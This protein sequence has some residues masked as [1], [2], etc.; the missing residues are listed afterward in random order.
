MGSIVKIFPMYPFSMVTWVFIGKKSF[1]FL[2]L[3]L[4][5]CFEGE[6]ERASTRG[7]Q[8]AGETEFQ[9][10]SE[11]SAQSLNSRTHEITTWAEIKSWTLNPVG[12]PSAPIGTKFYM[13]SPLQ[14]KRCCLP[15]KV[16]LQYPC[17]FLKEAKCQ[18]FHQ[19]I[20]RIM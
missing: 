20:C 16:T 13:E 18:G 11:P 1:K 9:A 3:N 7:G 19:G 15:S 10:D 12:H 5:I 6:G 4:F 2:K 8:R 14:L 17:H